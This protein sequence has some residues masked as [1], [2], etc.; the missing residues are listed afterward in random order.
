[1]SPTIEEAPLRLDLVLP[2]HNEEHRIDGTL[3]A[4]RS[5]LPGR[6]LRFWVA[7]D[8][9]RDATADIVRRHAEVDPRVGW[10]D[11]PKLGKGGVLTEAFRTAADSDADLIGFV[12]ADGATPPAEL[13]RLAEVVAA[14][15]DGAVASRRHPSAVT[16]GPRSLSRRITSAGFAFGIRLLFDVRCADTQCGAKV[17]RADVVRRV[18]PLLSARD[19]LFDVDL[20]H[21][22]H[23]LGF[24]ITEVPTVWVDQAGSRLRAGRDARRMLWS[25]LALWLHHRVVPVEGHRDDDVGGRRPSPRRAAASGRAARRARTRAG[26]D[27]QER[28]DGETL[29]ARA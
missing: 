28:H 7:L 23:R 12:D 25:S 4:Y 13:A 14:G 1:M 5:A 16:P 29:R 19:F 17:L 3:S 27:S 21:T 18:A 8:G 22:A 24:E 26:H 15:A 20:L 6:D 9:C 11:Y 10:V 2:A